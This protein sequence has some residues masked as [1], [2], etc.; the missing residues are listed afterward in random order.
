MWSVQVHCRQ[1]D[2]GRD[3]QF[4]S[5]LYGVGN[6]RGHRHLHQSAARGDSGANG[7][8]HPVCLVPA[9]QWIDSIHSRVTA[10]KPS[11][12]PWV[13]RPIEN[14]GLWVVC[15]LRISLSSDNMYVQW[16]PQKHTCPKAAPSAQHNL[17]LSQQ[18]QQRF[19]AKQHYVVV[20]VPKTAQ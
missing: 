20:Y 2:F 14:V 17:Q 13:I 5:L 18:Q 1:C 10:S 11:G 3:P 9:P 8:H 15:R 16:R 4:P 7:H 6:L 12:H 19:V